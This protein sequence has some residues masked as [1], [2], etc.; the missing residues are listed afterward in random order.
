[1]M[2]NVLIIYGPSG[3]GK[4][5][6]ASEFANRYV[7]QHFELDQM[8]VDAVN[9]LG[10]RAEWDAYYNQSDA[11]AL[12][13][14]LVRRAYAIDKKGAVLSLPSL[15]VPNDSQL[16]SALDCSA[17][18]VILYGSKENCMRSFVNREKET[19]RNLTAQHWEQH[20]LTSH[21]AFSKEKYELYRLEVF[22]LGSFT[23]LDLLIAEL[24]KRHVS[25]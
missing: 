9:E 3:V 12:C 6:I 25:L 21:E 14:E 24:Q 19:G 16:C 7:Y 17:T 10:L 11:R 1:M 5:T 2:R 4:S 13:E 15:V 18:P 23:P 8:G 22:R 20:N